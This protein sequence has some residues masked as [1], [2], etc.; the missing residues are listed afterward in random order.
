MKVKR[1]SGASVTVKHE[2]PPVS[3]ENDGVF[4]KETREIKAETVDDDDDIKVDLPID[5]VCC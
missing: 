4:R 1:A 2:L 3:D 5:Q